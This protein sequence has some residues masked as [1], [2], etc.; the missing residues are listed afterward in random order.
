MKEKPDGPD[1]GVQVALVCEE[2][3]AVRPSAS[4]RSKHQRHSL[5]L[6]SVYE[7]GVVHAVR[8]KLDGS[9]ARRLQ[10]YRA[11]Q[12][13]CMSD[14]N[15]RRSATGQAERVVRLSYHRYAV[16]ASGWEPMSVVDD[17][18]GEDQILEIGRLGTRECALRGEF[19]TIREAVEVGH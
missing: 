13:G 2:A 19:G 12:C 9:C 4:T 11:L 1:E 6:L 8:A 15:V 18:H 10:K 5:S 17:A 14:S 3:D 16:V 7:R